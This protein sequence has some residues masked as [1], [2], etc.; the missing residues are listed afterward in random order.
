MRTC[1]RKITSARARRAVVRGCVT[2]AAIALTGGLAPAV[3]AANGGAS[4]AAAP[5]L[6]LGQTVSSGWSNQPVNNEPGGEFWKVPLNGGDTVSIDISDASCGIGELVYAPGVTDGTLP[7][8]KAVVSE[9]GSTFT[10]TAPSSGVWTVFL[11]SGCATTSYDYAATVTRTS[12]KSENGGASIAAAPELVLGQTVSSGWSNQPANNEPGGEFWKVPLDAGETLTLETSA[13]SCGIGESVYA[14]GVTDGTLPGAKAVASTGGSLTFTAPSTGVWTVFIYSGC[15]TTS[16]DYV[17]TVAGGGGASTSG[18]GVPTG[19]AA[20]TASMAVARQ[21]VSVSAG[22]IASI[23]VA[24]GGA[25]CSGTLELTV[26]VKRATG[27]GRRKK[28]TTTL[29]TIGSVSFSGL[30]VGPHRLAVKLNSTGLRLLKHDGYKLS[31][32]ARATYSSGSIVRAASGTVS[33]KGKR[34]APASKG[35]TPGLRPA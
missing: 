24:C 34:P 30:S 16:Y 7:G 8:A 33:L 10:F 6:V 4:I 25:P 18:G 28:T 9:G 2:L 26:L 11:Y 12:G 35:S 22:G 13:A 5:E 19:K 17:A 29:V 15:P 21:L 20:P 14:P 1:R 31:A 3:A 23:G 27:T 32:T